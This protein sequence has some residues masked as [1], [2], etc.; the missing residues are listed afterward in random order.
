MTCPVPFPRVRLPRA[1]HHHR[2]EA[3]AYPPLDDLQPVAL[4]FHHVLSRVISQRVRVLRPASPARRRPADMVI[5][6]LPPRRRR[7]AM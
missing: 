1:S 7:S 5:V 6:P 3:M 2:I 4:A